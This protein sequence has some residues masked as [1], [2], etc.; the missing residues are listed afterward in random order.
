MNHLEI[1]ENSKN[2][3]LYPAMSLIIKRHN[4][5]FDEKLKGTEVSAAELPYLV[6]IYNDNNNITQRDLCNL[7]FVSE[8]VVA[9]TLKNLE[10]KGF[11]IRNNDPQ[12]K[13]RKLLSLTDKGV[14]ISKRMFNINA[15]WEKHL[16]DNLS[17]DEIENYKMLTK[18]LAIN[19]MKL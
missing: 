16:F 3:P 5:F 6:R 4:S 17:V 12:K 18:L 8:P 11:V 13:T 7:F 1:L 9:R 10:N 2:I 15:E 19:S 14:E